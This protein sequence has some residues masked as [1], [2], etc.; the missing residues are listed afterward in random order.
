ML[1]AGLRAFSILGLT[2]LIVIGFASQVF[3]QAGPFGPIHVTA[4]R[5]AYTGPGCPIDILYTATINFVWPHAG[6][7]VF[8]YHW[9]RSDGAKTP[10]QMIRPQPNQR[11]MTLR[12][13]WRLGA[14]GQRYS[15]SVTLFVNSG[16]THL[17]ESSPVVLVTCG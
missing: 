16:N 14:P 17:S 10:V 12:E 4:N 15:A 13:P 3:A 1:K 6:G 9:E 8:N 7:F 2:V 11:A 5:R